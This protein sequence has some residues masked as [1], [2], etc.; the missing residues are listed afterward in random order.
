MKTKLF[1]LTAAVALLAAGSAHAQLT[2]TST[3]ALAIPDNDPVGVSDDIV[4]P[5]NANITDLNIQLTVTHTWVGDLI[6]TLEHVDTAT[7]MVLADR[8]GVPASTFG[9]STDN[10][11]LWID[12]EGV[13]GNYEDT[14]LPTP[15]AITGSVVG[16]DP[17]NVTLMAAFDGENINGTWRLTVSDNAGGDTGTL[18][19]WTIEEPVVPVELQSFSIQ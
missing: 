19:S 9:C 12:D 1:V 17:A 4:V 11:D 6:F 5:D 16:G 7:T 2:Y 18:D 3:P 8:A 10:L 13:D 14:C 15:P